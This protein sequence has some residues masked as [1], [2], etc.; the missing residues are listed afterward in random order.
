MPTC[1]LTTGLLLSC[2]GARGLRERTI[3]QPCTHGQPPYLPRVCPRGWCG[4]CPSDVSR[5]M[6]LPTAAQGHPAALGPHRPP[7]S[8]PQVLP[9]STASGP[10]LAHLRPASPSWPWS[11][12]LP[13]L[14]GPSL[15]AALCT[16]RTRPAA[17][18]QELWAAV[19]G[20]RPWAGEGPGSSEGPATC[21]LERV[22]MLW[23]PSAPWRLWAPR[24][25]PSP[26]TKCRI[27]VR[28]GVLP[29]PTRGPSPGDPPP[30]GTTG[31]GAP[32]S[33][34]PSLRVEAGCAPVCSGCYDK[35]PRRVSL[36]VPTCQG[37]CPFYEVTNK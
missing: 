6:A 18:C 24:R 13:L 33:S 21:P 16:Q 15:L 20:E 22:M 25:P 17:T 11:L 3:P 34:Q 5:A 1:P 10:R 31:L 2:G 19:G 27:S 4:H 26:S 7:R 12:R 36:S 29:L 14:S 32:V 23:A 28:A 9:S 30:A 37:H 8:R 35:I